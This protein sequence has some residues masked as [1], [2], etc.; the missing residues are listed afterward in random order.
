M[1]ADGASASVEEFKA[2]REAYDAC[3]QPGKHF[4]DVIVTP[5]HMVLDE[6]KQMIGRGFPIV[7]LIDEGDAIETTH[8][9]IR[10]HPLYNRAM[11]LQQRQ[12]VTGE[13]DDVVVEHVSMQKG[14]L[15]QHIRKEKVAC[16]V[17]TKV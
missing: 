12:G 8:R 7:Y 17:L 1:Y 2:P 5:T 15:P 14:N 6:I 10:F 4:H 11:V 9:C 13:E 16:I 3:K